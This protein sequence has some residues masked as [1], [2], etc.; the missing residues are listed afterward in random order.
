MTVHNKRYDIRQA[1]H[2]Y[3]HLGLKWLRL[4]EEDHRVKYPLEPITFYA[5][6]KLAPVVVLCF[7]SVANFFASAGL[8][9]KSNGTEKPTC[10]GLIMKTVVNLILIVQNDW[11]NIIITCVNK[12]Y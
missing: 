3:V 5:T 9:F 7:L 8:L 4:S 6:M 1:R 2:D 11:E 10:A 12:I